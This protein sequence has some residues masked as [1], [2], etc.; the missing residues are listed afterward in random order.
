MRS[1]WSLPTV[2][3]AGSATEVVLFPDDTIEAN[4]Y[5]LTFDILSYQQPD[6]GLLTFYTFLI[7]AIVSQSVQSHVLG[8]FQESMK[9]FD[10]D[11]NRIYNGFRWK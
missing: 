2:R 3:V 9:S 4:L 5:L 8:L 11:K 7:S 10:R 1:F 6:N